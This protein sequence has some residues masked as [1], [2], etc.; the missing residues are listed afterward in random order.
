MK[1]T[2]ISHSLHVNR[3]PKTKLAK[4]AAELSLVP[5]RKPTHRLRL[6]VLMTALSSLDHAKLNEIVVI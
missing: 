2:N 5:T 6:D 4:G 1:G 3:L